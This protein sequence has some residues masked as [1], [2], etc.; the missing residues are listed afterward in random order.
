[1]NSPTRRLP[2]LLRPLADEPLD[3]WLEAYASRLKVSIGEFWTH[4]F[5]DRPQEP[6]VRGLF[7]RADEGF[8][9]DLAT[10]TGLSVDAVQATSSLGWT[11]PLS[12]GE[13]RTGSLRPVVGSHWCPKCL[14]ERAGRWKLSW[15]HPLIFGCIKHRCFLMQFCPE[16]GQTPRQ[17]LYQQHRPSL[18]YCSERA[19]NV[20]VS[21]GPRVPLCGHDLRTVRAPQIQQRS[22]VNLTLISGLLEDQVAGSR[23]AAD[24]LHDVH[25]M[26]QPSTLYPRPLTPQQTAKAVSASIMFASPTR[27]HRRIRALATEQL[28]QRPGPLPAGAAGGLS[29]ETRHIYIRARDPHMRT[30]DRLRYGS[31]TA[32]PV[33]RPTGDQSRVLEISRRIP[34]MLWPEASTAL[35]LTCDVSFSHLRRYG[36]LSLLIPGSSRSVPRLGADVDGRFE[37]DGF[38]HVLT[39]WGE[40]QAATKLLCSLVELSRGLESQPAPIDYARR[41]ELMANGPILDEAGWHRICRE[42]GRPLGQRRA[43]CH[44]NGYLYELITG[45]DPGQWLHTAELAKTAARIRYRKFCMEM[46]PTTADALRQV[47]SRWVDRH[48]L[49]E[50]LQWEPPMVGSSSP[51]TARGRVLP[52]DFSVLHDK[53]DKMKEGEVAA[54]M[55]LE[56]EHLRLLMVRTPRPPIPVRSKPP[57]QRLYRPRVGPLA[58][59]S[60]KA[61]IDAGAT[62]TELSKEIGHSRHLLASILKENGVSISS[63]RRSMVLNPEWLRKEYWDH[64]RTLSDIANEVGMNHSSLSRRMKQLGIPRR[65]RGA[66]SHAAHVTEQEARTL[67][68]LL[69]KALA[70]WQPIGRLERFAAL[71]D[72]PT[73]TSAAEA[74][75]CH[76][77]TLWEQ[78]RRLEQI[79]GQ[80]LL[81]R[82]TSGPGPP[83]RLTPAGRRLRSQYLKWRETRNP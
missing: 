5:P 78:L 20:T 26:S 80:T 39:Q 35:A 75:G 57:Q 10:A 62:I 23:D 63:G 12:H 73:L 29:D 6:I 59:A 22:F 49:N 34:S 66:W 4:V 47:A 19:T 14:A 64:R 27:H 36:P 70:S 71:A 45:G 17:H 79:V 40:S 61:R 42:T 13:K 46:R 67:P 21:M 3:S 48:E 32:E 51:G 8:I 33:A 9:R 52:I 41:E 16:C 68:P 77:A 55:G 82:H 7:A 11:R 44:A 24:R 54:E 74:L 58:P 56:L 60:L 2:I 28:G 69:R 76:Q 1:M 50:P 15:R 38:R 18:G 31:C 37:S 30:R 65:P 53:L 72:H 83:H 81:E 43:L 25:L